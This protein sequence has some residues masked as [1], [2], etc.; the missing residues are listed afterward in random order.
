LRG[1]TSFDVFCVKIGSGASAVARWKY[2]E[3]RSQVNIFDAHFRTY[4]EKKPL[5]GS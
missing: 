1:T 4:E 2:P 3:K 5:D